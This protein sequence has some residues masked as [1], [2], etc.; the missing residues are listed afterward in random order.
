M[1]DLLHSALETA[2]E[3]ALEPGRDG[4]AGV[5]LDPTTSANAMVFV[6]IAA[7]G[8]VMAL[9]YVPLRLFLTLTARTRRLRLLQRIR[10]LREE[11]GRPVNS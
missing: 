4:G 5:V 6:L 11:L 1:E 10:Q 7:L 9:I 2:M 8:L 3:S